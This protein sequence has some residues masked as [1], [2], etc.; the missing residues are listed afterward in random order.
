[1]LGFLSGDWSLPILPTLI[2]TILTLGMISQLYPTSGK[3]KISVLVYIFM[4]TGMGITSF[5]RLEALQTFPTLIIAIGASLFMVSDR[6]LGWNKFKTPF[7][8]A[9]GIILFT[10]YS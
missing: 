3:L 10:Y 1:M 6:M 5:G 9:E 8:L 2:I 7:Y 4:I